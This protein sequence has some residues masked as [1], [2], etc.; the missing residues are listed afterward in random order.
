MSRDMA[1]LEIQP[2]EMASEV[3]RLRQQNAELKM[4]LSNLIDANREI[5]ESLDTSSVLQ[6]VIENARSLTHARYGV[7]LTF[8]ESGN[9]QD[10]YTSGMTPEE[11]SS[12]PYSPSRRGLLG[13]LSEVEGPVGLADIASHPAS[14]G[15]PEDHPQMK[16]FL[17]VQVRQGKEH[18]GTIFLAEKDGGREFS[19]EDEET[20]VMFVPQA[21]SAIT[22]ARRY[23]HELRA[24]ADLEAILDITPVGL[25]VFDAKTEKLISYNS[26]FKRVADEEGILETPWEESLPL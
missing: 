3:D 14:I 18:V 21:A 24:K 13:Y 9:V 12:L 20:I 8:D 22:N 2:G 17:S 16:T 15:F 10:V 26:E 4:R 7:L 19:E 23:E 5:S 25:A 1:A 6:K 11:E